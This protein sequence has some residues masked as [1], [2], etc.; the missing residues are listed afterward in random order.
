MYHEFMT[1]KLENCCALEHVLISEMVSERVFTASSHVC[2]PSMIAAFR[3]GVR[4]RSALHFCEGE[5]S[6]RLENPTEQLYAFLVLQ[7]DDQTTE[8]PL[9]GAV[10]PGESI[11][12][13]I[14]NKGGATA[15]APAILLNRP[16]ALHE[17]VQ[18]DSAACDL[19]DARAMASLFASSGRIELYPIESKPE[20]QAP[21]PMGSIE[22]GAYPPDS[23]RIVAAPSCD[24]RF[25]N[26]RFA[27][28]AHDAPRLPP[29]LAV[30]TLSRVRDR[31]S[32]QSAVAYGVQGGLRRGVHL[33]PDDGLRAAQREHRPARGCHPRRRG[34]YRPLSHSDGHGA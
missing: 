30:R 34:R 27:F 1:V 32:P 4:D 17:A 26:P 19:F 20:E 16:I 13:V 7:S 31:L 14:K 21:L 33:R 22:L 25:T 28:P 8:M 29:S 15:E 10:A 12:I 23:L 9:A 6:V 3:V 5:V 18:I 24:L 11:E 2:L